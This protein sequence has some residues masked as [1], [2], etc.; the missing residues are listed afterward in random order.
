MTTR[1][2]VHSDQR[3]KPPP[4]IARDVTGEFGLSLLRLS[5]VASGTAH[6]AGQIGKYWIERFARP[7]E[8][9]G[10]FQATARRLGF[11]R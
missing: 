7:P 11:S 2:Q 6:F 9:L 5:I 4:D 3:S 10:V 8:R 1:L